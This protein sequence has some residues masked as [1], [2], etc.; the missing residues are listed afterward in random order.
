MSCMRNWKSEGPR[1]ISL[2]NLV[3][4]DPDE[5]HRSGVHG[6]RLQRSWRFTVP[7]TFLHSRSHEKVVFLNFPVA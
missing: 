2:A 5:R 3:F 7:Q 6:L 4:L 1:F